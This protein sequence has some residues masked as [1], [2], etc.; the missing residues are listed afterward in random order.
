MRVRFTLVAAGILIMGYAAA[1]A[2]ADPDLAPA[3]VLSFLA[4]VLILHDVV[5]MPALLVVGAAITRFVPRRRRPMVIAATISAA[6]LAIVA[7]PLVLGF[8]RPADNPSALPLPYGR[9]LAVLMVVLAGVA[10][11]WRRRAGDREDPERPASDDRGAG[12]G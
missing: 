8:G 7:S 3:G 10:M 9:N 12:D 4:G 1:G 11:L 5:W 6:A 2:L